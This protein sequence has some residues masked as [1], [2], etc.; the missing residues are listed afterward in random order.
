[1]GQAV[2]RARGPHT[3]KEPSPGVYFWPYPPPFSRQWDAVKYSGTQ[4]AD[5]AGYS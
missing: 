4:L 1:M 5:T 2:P 3:G